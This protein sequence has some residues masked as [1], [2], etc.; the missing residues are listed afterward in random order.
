MANKKEDHGALESREEREYMGVKYSIR[1]W[2]KGENDQPLYVASGQINGLTR[3]YR[4]FTRKS[5]R[6]LF[7]RAVRKS[8]GEK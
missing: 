5:A 2:G 8:L 7:K 6:D 3:T 4:S 1:V